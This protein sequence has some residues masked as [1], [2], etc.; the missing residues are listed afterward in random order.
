LAILG[1]KMLD[2]TPNVFLSDPYH[3]IFYNVRSHK[4]ATT[5]QL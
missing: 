5:V 2:N 4:N 3:A 1:H